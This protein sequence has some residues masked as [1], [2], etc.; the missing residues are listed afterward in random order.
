MAVQQMR[1]AYGSTFVPRERRDSLPFEPRKT[2]NPL[3]ERVC[4]MKEMGRC[5]SFSI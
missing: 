1:D 3:I 2:E 4:Y 5:Y